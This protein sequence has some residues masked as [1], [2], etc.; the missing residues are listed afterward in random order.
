M[1]GTVLALT[2]LLA[3]ALAL[4]WPWLPP[5]TRQR[6][7][8]SARAAWAGLRLSWV[9]AQHQRQA[10]RQDAAAAKETRA[11]IDRARRAA[12]DTQPG[13]TDKVS[14]IQTAREKRE[15]QKRRH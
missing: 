3:C 1:L 11:A 14:Q 12:S 4:A 5:A 8:A 7:H 6:W 2:A 9:R 15:A 10:R 13:A